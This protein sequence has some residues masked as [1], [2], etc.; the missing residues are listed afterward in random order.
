MNLLIQY[1]LCDKEHGRQ[2][3]VAHTFNLALGRQRHTDLLSWK[4]AWSTEPVPEWPGLHREKRKTH[5]SVE[6]SGSGQD[7]TLGTDRHN[8]ASSLCFRRRSIGMCG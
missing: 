7:Y 1:G 4:P 8:K 6:V 3:V 2:V 5:G